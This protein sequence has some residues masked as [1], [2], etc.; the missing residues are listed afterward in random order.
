MLKPN[1]SAKDIAQYGGYGPTK[2]YELK[3]VAIEQ[4]GGAVKYCPERVRV[5]SALRAMGSSLE[6]QLQIL[7]TIPSVSMQA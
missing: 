2:S 1:W 3:S 4:F 6:E 5:D 7:R